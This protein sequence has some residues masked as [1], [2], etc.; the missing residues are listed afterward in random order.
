MFLDFE[1]AFWKFEKRTLGFQILGEEAAERE[2]LGGSG[3]RGHCEEFFFIF[4]CRTFFTKAMWLV[5]FCLVIYLCWIYLRKSK[6]NFNIDLIN[7]IL[8]I[9]YTFDWG[10]TEQLLTWIG[11]C[12]SNVKIFGWIYLIRLVVV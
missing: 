5:R 4:Y 9:N 10:L 3:S 8:V 1:I 6:W 7:L 12:R 2:I 11:R